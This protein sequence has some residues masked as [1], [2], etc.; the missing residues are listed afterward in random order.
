[1]PRSTLLH[2]LLLGAGFGAAVVLGQYLP[3]LLP[4]GQAGR[5]HAQGRWPVNAPAD[6]SPVPTLGEDE[7]IVYPE[8]TGGSSSATN[9]F[10]AVT[11]S[12]GVGTSVLYLVDTQ[13]RQMAVYEARGGAP[14]QRRLV[15]VGARRIDLDLQL[16]GYNDQS[17]YD[18]RALET[19]FEKGDRK[20]DKQPPPVDKAPE[21]PK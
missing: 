8:D 1:M 11:G 3:M 17:E 10:L 20:A 16:R 9:G 5:L 12:Y 18:Y 21:L 2:S 4:Q 13:S 19:L 14:G 15:L 7:P 6:P